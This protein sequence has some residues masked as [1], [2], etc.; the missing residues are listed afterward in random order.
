MAAPINT[1]RY[2][3]ILLLY[4]IFICL[5]L[6]SVPASL[7]E[8]NLF[9]IKTLSYQEKLIMRQLDRSGVLMKEV[10]PALL[11]EQPVLEKYV[12]LQKEISAS[13]AFM[14]SIEIVILSSLKK[15]G[16]SIEKEYASRKKMNALFKKDSMA[17]KIQQNL[18]SLSDLINRYDTLLG[19]E[20]SRW[21]PA[22]SLVSTRNGKNIKWVDFF[23][24]NKPA[25]VSY[26]Q[27]KRIKLLLLQTQS[28]ISEQKNT[29]VAKALI[30]N[31]ERLNSLL[32]EQQAL[33]N[34]VTTS[35][36]ELSSSSKTESAFKQLQLD[37][38]QG[39]RLDRYYAGVSIPLLTSLPNL[40]MEDVEVE[41][42]P[43]VNVVRSADRVSAVFSNTGQYQ[44]RLFLR[45]EGTVQLLLTRSVLVQ[46]LPDPEV[47]LLPDNLNR[48]TISLSELLRISGLSTSLPVN[49]LS[50]VSL[51][52]NGFRATIIGAKEQ[53]PAVYN[54]GQVFQE[55]TKRLFSK[56]KKGDLVLFDNITLSVGDGSTRTAKS[57]LYKISD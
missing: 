3:L 39:I 29:L 34:S 13:Y 50:S 12:L 56:L 9:V 32:S 20:F 43:Q 42:T 38:L 2:R 15:Q 53:V 6:L 52:I 26:M 11:K 8:S 17:Q 31:Q 19:A 47:Y 23:F 54:Y 40:S 7:L 55:E 46:R 24:L 14:D 28:D 45:N 18:F 48:T 25:S 35:L 37:L 27:F 30:A 41:F 51:R 1:N 4:L 22:T 49:G 36:N 33:T 5:S 57:V 10:D 44:L 16:T 21:L